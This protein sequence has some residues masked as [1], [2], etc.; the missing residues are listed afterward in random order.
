MY[1][2]KNHYSDMEIIK[3]K[4]LE[5]GLFENIV[6][7]IIYIIFRMVHPVP[8]ERFQS[9]KD[10][11]PEIDTLLENIQK[12]NSPESTP[13]QQIINERINR[14]QATPKAVINYQLPRQQIHYAPALTSEQRNR[15]QD[16]LS[17]SATRYTE[18]NN[19][20]KRAEDRR[21]AKAAGR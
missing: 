19:I 17:S 13:E 3:I 15:I 6:N 7:N 4:L 18:F 5:K 14:R 21:V 16:S 12:S 9:I 2:E 20:F 11:L 8:S 10:L 1:T